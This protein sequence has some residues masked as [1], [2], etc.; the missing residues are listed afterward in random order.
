V[1]NGKEMAFVNAGQSL[2]IE[3]GEPHQVTGTGQMDCEYLSIT[4]PPAN[5]VGKK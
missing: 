1:Q 3:A 2:V 5:W 4:S